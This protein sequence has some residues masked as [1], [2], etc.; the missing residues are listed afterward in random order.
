MTLALSALRFCLPIEVYVVTNTIAWMADPGYVKNA[1]GWFQALTT[2]LPGY[3]PTW[4]FFRN[5]AASDLLFTA[6]YIGAMALTGTRLVASES[7]HVAHLER[8][9]VR[10]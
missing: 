4:T 2:G 1:A 8:I 3:P 10:S 5:S 9:V 6:L 7:Q